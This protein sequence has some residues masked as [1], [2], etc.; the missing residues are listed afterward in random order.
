VDELLS[1]LW[2]ESDGLQLG[3]D[4]RKCAEA[5]RWM[6]FGDAVEKAGLCILAA[7]RSN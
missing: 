4:G 5:G 2:V 1:C 7:L 3:G 6:T